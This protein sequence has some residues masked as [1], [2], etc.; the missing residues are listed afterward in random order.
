MLIQSDYHIHASFYRVKKA[1]DLPGP[2]AAE[3]LSASRA[4][5]NV[6]VGIVEHCNAAPKH[7]F[8]C[9]EEL[10]KEYYS[11]EFPRE[12]A[13]FGVESD[14][15][16][17]GSDHCGKEG[18]EKLKLH[19]VIGSVHLN[20]KTGLTVEEYIAQEHKRITNALKYNSNVDFIGHPSARD[21][22]GSAAAI[23]K[24]GIGGSSLKTLSKMSCAAP[25]SRAR[26]WKSTVPALRIRFIWTFSRGSGMIKSFLRWAPRPTEPTKPT[27]PPLIG[28]KNLMNSD[29][30][31]NTIGE[32]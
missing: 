18:R 32:L 22:A 20:P 25:G 30:K 2:I 27:P 11:P 16:E 17:D 29:L 15:N 31:K 7:P 28:R 8:Y 9:L 3:Q 12:N 19:Y 23:L 13:F 24:T 14:L 26:L 4:A 1:D 6:Y 21:S 5:G 10:A